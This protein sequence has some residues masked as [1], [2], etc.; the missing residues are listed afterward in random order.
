M[1]A[2]PLRRLISVLALLLTGA[3]AWV[4]GQSLKDGEE[5]LIQRRYAEAVPH[6]RKAYEEAGAGE[7]DRVLLLL[8]RAL[9]LSGNSAEAVAAYERL[10]REI[11]GSNLATKATFQRAEVLAANRRFQEAAVLYRDEIERL[12]GIGRKEEIAATYL[13]LAEQALNREPADHAR[14]VQ[15]FDLAIDLGLSPERERSVKLLAAEARLKSNQLPDAILRFQPLAKTLTVEQGRRRAMLGLGRA[16][17]RSGE[18]GKARVTFQDLIALGKEA[19][20]AAEAAYEI[21]L[22]FQVPTPAPAELDRAVAALEV[23]ARDFPKHEKARVA[24]FLLAQCYQHVGRSEAALAAL[25]A[26]L[27]VPGNEVLPEAAQARAMVGDVLAAQAK[28]AEAIAAWRA[29]LKAHPAH[30][31]WER[32]QRAI[33]DTEYGMAQAAFERGKEAAGAE[34]FAEARQRYDTFAA[35]YPLDSRN[36]EIL[37][38]LGEMLAI[39]DRHDAARE[40]FARCV[41]KYPNTESSSHAQ[42]RIGEIFESKTFNYLEALRAYRAVTWGS[43][44]AHAQSRLQRL[45]RKHLALL[46]ARTYRTDEKPVFQITSRNIEK[47]RV[48]VFRLDLETWFRATHGIADVRALDIEVIEPDQVLESV[49]KDYKPYEETQRDLEIPFREPG[50]YVVKVDDKELEATTMVVVSDL[51]MLTKTSRH[52]L[53]VFAQNTK[54]NRAEAG[55]RVVLSDGGKVLAEGATDQDGLWRFKGKELQTSDRLAVFT[56]NAAGSGASTV[57]L[58]GLGYAPGLTPKGYLF[59]D[60]PAYQPGQLVHVKGIVREVKDGLYQLPAAQGYQ[61]KVFSAGGRL[62]LSRE[63]AFTPF[64][65]FALDLP[66]PAGAELGEWRVAV[67]RANGEGETFTGSFQVARYERPRLALR[68]EARTPVVF[69]GERLQGRI[70]AKHF[71]GEP[72]A[73]KTVALTLYLP[74]GRQ[75]P[76]EAQTNAAGEV[77]FDFDTKDF[78]EEALAV[79]DAMAVED[80]ARTRLTVPV[81]TTEFTA[82]LSMLRPV[83][84]TGENFDVTIKLQ[85]RAGKPLARPGVARLYRM[86]RRH[87]RVTEVESARKD[88]A[89]AAETG[90]ATVSFAADKGG[91][92]RVRIEAKDRFGTLVTAELDLEISGKDDQVKLRLLSDRQEGRVGETLQVKVVNRVGPRLVLET[93]QGDGVLACRPRILPEG[94]STIALA[95]EPLHAP[96]FALGLAMI[97][98]DKLH[99]AERDFVVARDL[100]V[101]VEAPAAA[102]APGSEVELVVRALD[103]RGQPVEGEFALAMVDEALLAAYP[104][105]TAAIGPFFYGRRRETQFRTVSSCTWSFR[106]E[107]RPVP[108]EI[109][110]EE[111]RQE[112]RKSESLRALYAET[113]GPAEEVPQGQVAGEPGQD[114]F[115]GTGWNQVQGLG[116]GGAAKLGGRSAA[117]NAPGSA[118][119]ATPGPAGR[120]GS[121]RQARGGESRD[122]KLDEQV[123]KDAEGAQIVDSIESSGLGQ[124]AYYLGRPKGNPAYRFAPPTWEAQMGLPIS[125]LLPFALDPAAPLDRPR[126]DFSETGAWLSAVVTGKDGVGRA[127]VKLPDST[128]GFA[129]V[130]RGVTADTYVGEGR[131]ALRTVKE[132]Q[133]AVVAPPA[134]VEGDRTTLRAR[135]HNL[136]DQEASIALRLHTKAGEAARE[137]AHSLA[138]RPRQEVE[139]GFALTASSA[140]DLEVELAAESG[141]RRDAVRL[142]I[143]VEPFGI[144]IRDGHSGSTTQ[145]DAFTLSLPEGREYTRLWMAIELGT[146]SGAD[147]VAMALGSGWRPWNCV[148]VEST[149]RAQAS[150]AFATA[151][152]LEYLERVGTGNAADLARLKSVLHAAVNSLSSSQLAD[153]GLPWIGVKSADVR[154]TAQSVLALALARRRGIVAA[155]DPL[156]KACEFLLRSRSGDARDRAHAALALAMAGRARFEDLNALHRQRATLDLESLARLGLAFVAS[157][158]QDLGREVAEVLRGKLALSAKANFATVEA[159][160]LA[161]ATLLLLDPKDQDG[162]RVVEWLRG[163]RQGVSYGTPEATAAALWALTAAGG[164][165]RGAASNA[166][167]R[168]RVNGQDLA[169]APDVARQPQLRFEVPAQWLK[170]RGNHVEIAVQGQGRVHYAAVLNGFAKGFRPEDRNQRLARVGRNY[171]PAFLRHDNKVIQPGFSTVAGR[172]ESFVNPVT[173]LEVGKVARVTTTLRIADDMRAALTPMVVEEPIPAGCTVP[174]ESIQGSFD[175]VV[176][177]PQRLT[178]YYRENRGYDDVRYE[179]QARFPGEYR[180]LPTKVYGAERPDLVAHGE[181][182]ALKVLPR[183]EPTPDAYRLTPDE[184]YQLG[185]A[186][187]DADRLEEAGKHL[188]ALLKGWSLHEHVFKDVAR[189]MLFVS[190]ARKDSAATVRFFEELKDRFPD[191]VIPFDKIV[192]VA[193]AYLDLGE[194]ERALMVFRATAEA[195]FLK[196]AAVATTLEQLGEVKASLRFLRRLLLSYPDLNT[197]RG[198]LY[199]VGQ[200]LASLAAQMPEGTPPNDKVGTRAE[201]RAQALATLREFLVLYPD[202]SMAEEVSFAYA[203]TFLEAR[204]HRAALAASGAALQRY[205]GTV[206]EDELLYAQG[207]CH[208]VLGEKEKA[209]A[210]LQRVAEGEFPRPGGGK[211]ASENR[212]HAIYLQG[213]IHHA[214]GEPEKALAAYEKVKDRFSDAVEASEFFLRKALSLPEVTTFALADK[215]EVPVSY[216]NVKEV[217]V[218]VYRVDLMRL[219]L[220]EKSLNDIRGVQLHGIRPYQQAKVTLGEGRDYRAKEKKLELELKDPGAYL[221]VARGDD[222]LAS[223]MVLRSDLKIETQESL[224]VGR[225]RVNVKRNDEFLADAHV[226]V[227]GS[228]DGR[229][230]SGESDLRGVFAADALVGQATVIV[231]KGDEYA[232]FRGTGLHQPAAALPQIQARQQIQQAQQRVPARV[233]PQQQVFDALNQNIN[234]NS[235]NRARQMNWLQSEVLNKQQKGVEVGR[236]KE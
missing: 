226:K 174:R 68:A 80:G 120:P 65:S 79:L 161:G 88:F 8:A 168:V 78:A 116:G 199:G 201:L 75:V 7:K 164:T 179:L 141:A 24:P 154:S 50:A 184:L 46:T 29:Y 218:K 212:Y 107:A 180:A 9:F 159:V 183:G 158:R 155:Q 20:E 67:D 223:G 186:L 167:V 43:W 165:E 228:V 34:R 235:D 177:E 6:L 202:D 231:K 140:R 147:L 62:M 55:V 205:P 28:P 134:L 73:G 187:Y 219:Y 111:R 64:G 92:H 37:Y 214:L 160:G 74:D 36:P 4:L 189:M 123:L 102:Q 127:K 25:L 23:L 59:T 105:Q 31:E 227:V 26:F 41:S 42:F 21:A 77:P 171:E 175:H 91:A 44:A 157:Q 14:A 38:Q 136:T 208:F 163:Q 204:D 220:L 113:R 206:F 115:T 51:A 96:N 101:S 133:A 1:H 112:E 215:V 143:P 16:Q 72:A 142:T 197:M 222:L 70:V 152:V 61:V 103:P 126:T 170:E 207:Y 89:S 5:A 198:S 90:V 172:I 138:A 203:T 225:I 122:K 94:E 233:V 35:A 232:F 224:D 156:H 33:V 192:A 128:T 84:L 146:S 182:R 117:R 166:E 196:E 188:D 236:T 121:A 124:D 125:G 148:Q 190:V 82:A 193:R 58:S 69:R 234:L 60:R 12:V 145:G 131:T 213:Q 106:G 210:I 11:P 153:G 81:V 104:E 200:K 173:A 118:G 129:V 149:H 86:E 57:S 13:G 15:F 2:A 66:L 162:A 30:A 93:L 99:L 40:A 169:T 211:G 22:T 83:F 178:F 18:R 209:F 110:A 108:Q 17:L 137:E 230:R 176:V 185:K 151:L 53:L 56:V 32:V 132:L 52:E 98:G 191:L 87:G 10:S 181:A 150:R 54:E 195:S 3:F 135:A 47:L 19:A 114:A 45:E 76:H 229:F 144:E 49:V 221:V 95:L 130:A 109:L 216:R 27:E 217:E 39:E 194:F 97:D 63:V 71:F 48:R 119:P 100:R 85:D 139:H